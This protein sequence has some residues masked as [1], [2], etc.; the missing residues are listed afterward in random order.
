[1]ISVEFS[2]DELIHLY[3]VVNQNYAPISHVPDNFTQNINDKIGG[4]ILPKLWKYAKISEDSIM[5]WQDDRYY[6]KPLLNEILFMGAGTHSLN[7]C[8]MLHRRLNYAFSELSGRQQN[9]GMGTQFDENFDKQAQNNIKD[10]LYDIIH[11]FG[12]EPE[13]L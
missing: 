8:N 2:E 10:V 9:G 7:E 4:K 3:Q 1:M 6:K 5:K 13:D 11:A 12:Y